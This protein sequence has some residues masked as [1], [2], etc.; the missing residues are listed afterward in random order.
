LKSDQQKQADLLIQIVN[1]GQKMLMNK[2][3]AD[4]DAQSNIL[5]NSLTDIL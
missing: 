3:N 4:T 2:K 5:K 1:Q